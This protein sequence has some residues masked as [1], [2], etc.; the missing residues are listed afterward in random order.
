L[1]REKVADALAL[2]VW[3]TGTAESFANTHFEILALVIRN[4]ESFDFDLVEATVSGNGFFHK[5]FVLG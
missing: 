3:I 5:Q 4:R 2:V 1:T